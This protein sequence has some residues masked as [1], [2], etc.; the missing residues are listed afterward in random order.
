MLY[1]HVVP[2]TADEQIADSNNTGIERYRVLERS[3]LNDYFLKKI[4]YTVEWRPLGAYISC[5]YK[6]FEFKGILYRHKMTML[7]QNDIQTV[8]E[9]YLLHMWRKDV[10]RRHSSIFFAE[11]YPHMTEEYNKF[12]EVEKYFQQCADAAMGSLKKMEYIKEMCIDMKNELI[13]WNSR[14]TTTDADPSVWASQSLGGTPVSD[15]NVAVPRG[16]PRMQRCVSASEAQGRGRGGRRT[17]NATRTSGRGGRHVSGATCGTRGGNSH[18][19]SRA[20]SGPT[21]GD[22]NNDNK[23]LFNLNK[24]LNASQA[25]FVF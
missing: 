21:H 1:C 11:G 7:A 20:A 4:T 25:S 6:K 17:T 13:N 12:Q 3:I 19:G 18:G 16:R 8:N 22:N 14:S 5:N 9:R 2:P 24:D 10:Y 15:P 23:F